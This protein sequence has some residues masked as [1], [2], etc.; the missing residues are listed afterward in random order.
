M[1][2]LSVILRSCGK[3]INLAK[4]NCYQVPRKPP[5]N[6]LIFEKLPEPSC[7]D[8]VT[9]GVKGP[10]PTKPVRICTKEDLQTFYCP[11]PCDCKVKPIPLTWTQKII[12]TTILI[13]KSLIVGGLVYYTWSEGLWSDTEHSAILYDKLTAPKETK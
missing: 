5:L 3:T 11:P 2:K 7:G 4:T 6:T 10:P 12:K 8:K 1:P 9:C 13:V